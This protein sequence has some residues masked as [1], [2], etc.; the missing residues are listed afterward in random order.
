MVSW[1]FLSK[2]QNDH[3]LTRAATSIHMVHERNPNKW[4]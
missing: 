4:I 1:L 3:G 2:S